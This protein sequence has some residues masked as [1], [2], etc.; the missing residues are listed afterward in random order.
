M[1]DLETATLID[2][3]SMIGTRFDLRQGDNVIADVTLSEAINIGQSKR[4]GG[5]VSLVFEGAEDLTLEQ[6]TF[7]LLSDTEIMDLFLVPIGPFGKGMGFE[8]VLT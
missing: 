7:T 4:E 1:I 6:G 8:A 3:K 2:F 5:A